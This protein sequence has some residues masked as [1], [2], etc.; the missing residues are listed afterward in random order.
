MLQNEIARTVH[1]RRLYIGMPTRELA[2]RCGW[3]RSTFDRRMKNP[4]TL[5]LK[6]MW[7][8]EKVLKM[9]HGTLG[10]LKV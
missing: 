3:S 4:E 5:S 8:L 6:E 9:E 10:G 1:S 2:A 7:N